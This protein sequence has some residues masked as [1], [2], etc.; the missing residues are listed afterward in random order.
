MAKKV[1]RREL[2][3]KATRNDER[4]DPY[5]WE[6]TLRKNTEKYR[7]NSRSLPLQFPCNRFTLIGKRNHQK[8]REITGFPGSVGPA[9]QPQG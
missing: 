1:P 7:E 9:F 8:V 4:L 5:V 2:G 6:K 3:P